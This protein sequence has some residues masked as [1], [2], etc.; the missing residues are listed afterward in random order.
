MA[1]ERDPAHSRGT[2]LEQLHEMRR[3]KVILEL[4]EQVKRITMEL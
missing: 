4:Q 1:H 2:P 3:D